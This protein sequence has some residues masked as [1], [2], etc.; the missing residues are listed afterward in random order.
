MRKNNN[1]NNN[2]P[3][4]DTN[5]KDIIMLQ[6]SH[7]IFKPVSLYLYFHEKCQKLACDIFLLIPS[8]PQKD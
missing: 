5:H 6:P 3:S 2:V 7:I 1:N 8:D 4:Q